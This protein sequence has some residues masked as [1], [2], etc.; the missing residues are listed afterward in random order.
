MGATNIIVLTDQASIEK[1][2]CKKEVLNRPSQW[3]AQNKTTGELSFC[4]K[5]PLDD[6]KLRHVEWKP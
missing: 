4:V 6:G 2:L 1:Y 3:T 5:F